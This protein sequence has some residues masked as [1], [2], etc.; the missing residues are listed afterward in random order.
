MEISI[1]KHAKSAPHASLR[2]YLFVIHV[3]RFKIE[4]PEVSLLYNYSSGI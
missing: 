2:K 3:V 4:C 1:K